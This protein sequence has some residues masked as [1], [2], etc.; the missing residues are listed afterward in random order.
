[1]CTMPVN[2]ALPVR[3]FQSTALS[4]SA[5]MSRSFHTAPF[6]LLQGDACTSYLIVIRAA[7]ISPRSSLQSGCEAS[8]SSCCLSKDAKM[9]VH[10]FSHTVGPAISSTRS[11]T[12]GLSPHGAPSAPPLLH[13]AHCSLIE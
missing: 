13:Q 10:R 7:C 6:P 11:Y 2:S 9:L 1:M 3:C 12:K 4:A 5:L 8:K